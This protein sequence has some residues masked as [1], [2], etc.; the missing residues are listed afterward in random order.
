MA[1]LNKPGVLMYH[2]AI[3]LLFGTLFATLKQF[4]FE[5]F[6]ET[7]PYSD[8]VM[9]LIFGLVGATIAFGFVVTIAS[10]ISK[11]RKSSGLVKVM[12]TFMWIDLAVMALYTYFLDIL[13]EGLTN[14]G[15]R[16]LIIILTSILF[17]ITAMGISSGQSMSD[18]KT[19]GLRL[20]CFMETTPPKNG[21]TVCVVFCKFPGLPKK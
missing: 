20:T 3:F 19:D 10:L 2:V 13:D 21:S 6:T 16:Y 15:V 1:V 4:N 8:A 5:E 11:E 7:A 17:F 14:T 9:I 12:L 18:R